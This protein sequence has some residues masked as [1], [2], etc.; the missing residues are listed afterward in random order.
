MDEL[1]LFKFKRQPVRTLTIDGEV[2][3][4]GKDVCSVLGYQNPSKALQDHVDAEDKL[5]N[6]TLSSL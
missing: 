5:N 4:V 6:E 1:T 3:F 2:W